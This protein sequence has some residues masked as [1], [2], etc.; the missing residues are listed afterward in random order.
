MHAEKGSPLL[1]P[2]SVIRPG[3]SDCPKH[4]SEKTV[5]ESIP[6]PPCHPQVPE[7]HRVF[8]SELTVLS[9]GSCPLL[10]S[11]FHNARMSP[12]PALR[13]SQGGLQ[14]QTSLSALFRKVFPTQWAAARPCTLPTASRPWRFV[15]SVTLGQ[16]QLL[17]SATGLFF[18]SRSVLTALETSSGTLPGHLLV[19]AIYSRT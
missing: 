7:P 16:A 10:L 1:A 9:H 14:S 11:P 3:L 13:E 2:A 4:I 6:A 8:C 18:S 5:A 12:G 17:P 15:C 19:T